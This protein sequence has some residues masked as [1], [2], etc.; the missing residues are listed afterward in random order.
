MLVCEQGYI[1]FMLVTKA[2][3]QLA[4][5]VSAKPGFRP[6]NQWKNSFKTCGM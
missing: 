6:S 3:V 5:S 4:G 1:F 2:D